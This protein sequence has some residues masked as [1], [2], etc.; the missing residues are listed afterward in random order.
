MRPR[1]SA[2]ASE[3]APRAKPNSSLSISSRGRAAQLIATK[4]PSRRL[5]SWMAR[6][7]TSLPAP[8][9]PVSRI[10][11]V[12][13]ASLASLLLIAAS[14]GDA[15]GTGANGSLRSRS[16]AASSTLVASRNTA[17]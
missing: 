6:A 10:S 1:L 14:A 4:R 15:V 11:P 9:S 5:A 8:V 12:V 13:G 2:L 3:W 7:Y 17:A 16:I